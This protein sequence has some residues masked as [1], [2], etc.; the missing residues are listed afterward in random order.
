LADTRYLDAAERALKAASALMHE[1]PQAHMTLLNALEDFLT[2]MQMVII[3]GPAADGERWARELSALY[4]PT[5]LVF[6]IPGDAPGLP[7]AL[8]AKPA[9]GSVT[10][11]VCAGMACGAPQTDLRELA[12]RLGAG[13][14]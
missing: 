5:R 1:Y 11:Y 13:V 2:S 3:R 12:R 7:A 6:A 8:A 4:A 9:L 14:V 10:A